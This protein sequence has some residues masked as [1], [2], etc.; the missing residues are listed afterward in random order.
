MIKCIPIWKLMWKYGIYSSSRFSWLTGQIN[1]I[2][3]D[4]NSFWRKFKFWLSTEVET[5]NVQDVVFGVYCGF[6]KRLK[7]SCQG[8]HMRYRVKSHMTEI[9]NNVSSKKKLYKL[10]NSCG[11]KNPSYTHTH[12]HIAWYTWTISIKQIFQ[13][14]RKIKKNKKIKW[15]L[16]QFWL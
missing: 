12:T 5:A 8:S 2:G 1:E 7:D 15:N 13:P 11:K 10:Q 16:E 14:N 4:K 6:M 9:D 3:I